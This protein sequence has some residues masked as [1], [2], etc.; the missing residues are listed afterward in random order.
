MSYAGH[1]RAAPR[2]MAGFAAVIALHVVAIYALVSGS[3]FRVVQAIHPPLM[4]K[5]IEEAKPPE[6]APPPPPPP[7]VTAPPPP[8]MPM[9]EIQIRQPP[10][11][12]HAI[13]QVTPT[14]PVAPPP[15]AIVQPVRQPVHVPPVAAASS[16]RKPEYPPISRRLEE[17]GTV[18]L[19]F[20]I[21]TNGKVIDS[22]VAQ[23]SGHE[24]LDDAARRALSLCVFKPGTVDG[25]PE[26][27]WAQI[28]YSWTLN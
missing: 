25:T 14:K 2:K 24:R 4:T 12:P 22:K 20:L 1:E 15:P 21:D 11:T 10:P 16:C 3:A 13:T 17:T 8:F 26:K 6:Q 7:T 5:I 19:S 18:T 28:R 23:S 9:P 27:A